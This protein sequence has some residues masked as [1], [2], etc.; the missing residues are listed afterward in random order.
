MFIHIGL[1]SSNPHTPSIQKTVL[2][3]CDVQVNFQAPVLIEVTFLKRDNKPTKDQQKEYCHTLVWS[4][5]SGGSCVSLGA[6][7]TWEFSVLSA[8]SCCEYKTGLEIKGLPW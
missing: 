2:R 4:V 8:H 6:G 5:D 3:V 1:L 7:N